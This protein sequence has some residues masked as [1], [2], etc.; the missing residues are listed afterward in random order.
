MKRL[1][2]AL[3]SVALLVSPITAVAQGHGGGFHGG[4]AHGAGGFHGGAFHGGFR[5]GGFRGGGFRGFRGPGF[6]PFFGFG[7][8]FALAAAPWYYGFPDYWWDYGP[9]YPYAYGPYGYYGPPPPDG[10]PVGPPPG[11][12]TAPPAACGSWV[13]RADHSRYQW[14]PAPC[15]PAAPPAGS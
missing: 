14:V 7:L 9:P 11:A 12:A 2:S 6:F 4:A 3:A 8:G 10:P 1:V 15:A 13:W 5:G